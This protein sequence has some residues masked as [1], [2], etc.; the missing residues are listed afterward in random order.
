MKIVLNGKTEKIENIRTIKDLIDKL[1]DS[2]PKFFAVEKNK[3]IIY[4][5][6]YANCVL[7]ENDEVEIVIFAGGG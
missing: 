5:E 7:S 3:E 6:N 2:L 1:G 4:K